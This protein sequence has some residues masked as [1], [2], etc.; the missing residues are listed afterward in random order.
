MSASFRAATFN[1]TNSATIPLTKPTGTVAGDLMLIATGLHY[2]AAYLDTPASWTLQDDVTAP[3]SAHQQLFSLIAGSSEPS[4]VTLGVHGGSGDTPVGVRATFTGVNA[5]TP[6]P[7][8]SIAH[9]VGGATQSTFTPAS[10]SGVVA[11]D[12]AAISLFQLASSTVPTVGGNWTIAGTQ[13]SVDGGIR[14][15]LFINTVDT[16]TVAG[17][18]ITL[19][20]STAS[21]AATSFRI[22]AAA[23]GSAFKSS[24]AANAN[25]IL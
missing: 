22:A 13:F 5:T 9:A 24:F 7:A 18:V 3:N 1:T 11:G 10:I 2:G 14:E 21:V 17:P 8:G 12:I 16:G 25:S 20:L 23:G 4:S 19:G 15:T 6:I